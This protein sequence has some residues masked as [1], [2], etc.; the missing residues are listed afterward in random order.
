MKRIILLI[1]ILTQ[2]ILADGLKI[3]ENISDIPQ[4]KNVVLIFSMKH[5]PYCKRQERSILKKVQPKFKEVE[6]LKVMKDSKVFHE[7]NDSG[8][9]DDIE[10]YPTTFI[11]KIE[12]GNQMFIKYHFVGFQRPSNIINVLIDKDIMDD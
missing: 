9:F 11:L 8:N 12:Q 4:N 1:F 5:C 3:I 6:Y 2:T 10:Y 7:L